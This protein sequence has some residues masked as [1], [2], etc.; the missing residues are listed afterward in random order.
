M[1]SGSNHNLCKCAVV[2]FVDDSLKTKETAT[3]EEFVDDSLKTEET[4]TAEEPKPIAL[5]I[6]KL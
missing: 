6:Y 2:K 1:H 4:A 3:V 5:S